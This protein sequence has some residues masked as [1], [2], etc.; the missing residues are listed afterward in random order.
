MATLLKTI[1][2]FVWLAA[3]GGVV[4]Y[5]LQSHAKKKRI[6]EHGIDGE[7]TILRMERTL[8]QVNRRF[9]YD[10]LLEFKVPGRPAYQVQ[11][12][13]RAHDWNA[14]ILEPNV[15]LKVKVDPNNPQQFVVLGA[16]G[17]QR[18]QSLQALFAGAAAAAEARTAA[19]AD[20]V[21]ALKDLQTML[22]SDLITQ[23]EYD[24]KRAAILARL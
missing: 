4:W 1:L 21:K 9:V 13:S 6:R 22:D 5:F 8:M 14:F 12:S 11:H 23:D 10:F 17:Q 7:A 3:V 2:L 19:P 16:I 15:R 20:P 18:P 24:Q